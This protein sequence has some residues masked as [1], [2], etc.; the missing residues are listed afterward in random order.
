MFFCF[1]QDLK[2]LTPNISKLFDAHRRDGKYA[3]DGPFENV[4]LGLSSEYQR[5]R[6]FFG[7]TC[8]NPTADPQV[9]KAIAPK[10]EKPRSEMILFYQCVE[11]PSRA[12]ENDGGRDQFDID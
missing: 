8:E 9:G 12:S 10:I 3:P 7:R 5:L 11:A 2:L 6:P 1:C 4:P